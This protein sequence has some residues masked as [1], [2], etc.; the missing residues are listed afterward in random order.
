MQKQVIWLRGAAMAAIAAGLISLPMMP[1]AQA[2]QRG[3]T[4]ISQHRAGYNYERH[5]S[6]G[7]LNRSQRNPAAYH[8]HFSL[9]EFDPQYHGSNGG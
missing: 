9:Q 1:V 5:W 4:L 2:Q 3:P 6:A 7:E 8:G